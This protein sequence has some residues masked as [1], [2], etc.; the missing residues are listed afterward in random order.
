MNLNRKDAFSVIFLNEAMNIKALRQ[1][2]KI[3]NKRRGLCR[4]NNGFE[5]LPRT[6]YFYRLSDIWTW[7]QSN[8]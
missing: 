2:L 7:L 5:K 1:E 4:S 3:E 6:S 8:L